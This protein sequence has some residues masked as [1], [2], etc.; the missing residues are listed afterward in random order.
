MTIKEA[1]E[2]FDALRLANA[3][4]LEYG[5]VCKWRD[6]DQIPAYW[7]V[8]FVN[9]MNHHNV[10]ISLHD[11][12]GWKVP[13]EGETNLMRNV[14]CLYGLCVCVCVLETVPGSIHQTTLWP[15][16]AHFTRSLLPLP[17]VLWQDARS[18]CADVECVCVCVCRG[19]DERKMQDRSCSTPSVRPSSPPKRGVHPHPPSQTAHHLLQADQRMS[20]V[21]P[22]VD[23]GGWLFR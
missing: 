7:R 6:R 10:A 20:R 14:L 19:K 21:E 1:F 4:G 23:G 15:N 12:A 2:Q 16:P 18:R 11:L 9:L 22:G 3:L 5:V 8:K 13:M 17:S